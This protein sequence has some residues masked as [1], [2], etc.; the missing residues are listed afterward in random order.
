MRVLV[1]FLQKGSFNSGE[2]MSLDLEKIANIRIS[3]QRNTSELLTI[4]PENPRPNT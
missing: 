2:F 1:R 3:R 4:T